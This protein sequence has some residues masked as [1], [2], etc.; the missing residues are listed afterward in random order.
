M[1]KAFLD[2][3]A[4]AIAPE[5]RVIIVTDAGFQ[6]TWFRHIR[7]LGWDFIGRIR[8]NIQLRLQEKGEQWLTRQSLTAKRKPEDLGSGT[9]AR[10]EYAQ[11]DGH[12][13]LHKKEAKGRKGKR[14]RRRISRYSQ[15]RDGRASANE[16]WL[17]F[18]STDEFSPAKVMKLYSRRMQIEQ[19]FRDERVNDLV[20]V[21][22]RV[23][24][25]QK[26]EFWY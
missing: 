12:F 2:A 11:C 16:P 10:A 1:Q 14:A 22:A 5:T 3:L 8:G 15:E 26:G 7:S 21:F 17:I 4:R 9:L 20:L 19:H 18:S 6:N 25:V 24:V 23:T 13:Y